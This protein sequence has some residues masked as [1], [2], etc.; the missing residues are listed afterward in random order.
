MGGTIFLAVPIV[1]YAATAGFTLPQ[2]ALYLGLGAIFVAYM[3]AHFWIWNLPMRELRD[4]GTSGEARSRAEVKQLLLEKTTYGQI[5]TIAGAGIVLLLKSQSNGGM[6]SG[7]NPFWAGLGAV[8]LVAECRS[9][10]SKMALRVSAAMTS[11]GDAAISSVPT[12]RGLNL[13]TNNSAVRL[14]FRAPDDAMSE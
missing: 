3:A 6:L 10:T 12:L 7:W 11:I 5:A 9:S 13:A 1:L 2:M 8:G 14:P 4:R